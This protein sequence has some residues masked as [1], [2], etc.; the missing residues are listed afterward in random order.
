MSLKDM[1]KG[2]KVYLGIIAG[3]ILLAILSA[4]LGA[5]AFFLAVIGLIFIMISFTPRVVYGRKIKET[6]SMLLFTAVGAA[7]LAI[8][9][10]IMTLG[11]SQPGALVMAGMYIFSI[12]WMVL[13]IILIRKSMGGK[14][15]VEVADAIDA[16][17]GNTEIMVDNNTV[18]DV[19]PQMQ[20]M[21]QQQ[22]TKG[23]SGKLSLI[24]GIIC[25]FSGIFS[26]VLINTL[27]ANL[28]AM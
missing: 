26:L 10:I 20:Q 27:L 8:A 11:K 7:L 25:L 16:K 2:K 9:I 17:A 18:T 23:L 4:L 19:V 5:R 28:Y 12:A 21:P 1:P 13:G 15:L 24:L 14:K 22:Q 3:L 6:P